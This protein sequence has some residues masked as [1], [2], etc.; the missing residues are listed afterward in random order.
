MRHRGG[1][2]QR[3]WTSRSPIFADD[4]NGLMT[5]GADEL[6]LGARLN[7]RAAQGRDGEITVLSSCSRGRYMQGHSRVMARL[8]GNLRAAAVKPI[9]QEHRPE[10]FEP[11]WDFVKS[12]AV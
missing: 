2:D 11:G 7:T 12:G 4:L 1:N 8:A 9:N 10:V 5:I 6:R 3:P